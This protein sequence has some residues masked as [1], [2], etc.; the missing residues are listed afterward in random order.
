MTNS[1]ISKFIIDDIPVRL[2]ERIYPSGF[3]PLKKYIGIFIPSVRSLEI[4]EILT[5]NS[6]IQTKNIIRTTSNGEWKY[7]MIY[8]AITDHDASK[9]LK[10]KEVLSLPLQ[11]E[12]ADTEDDLSDLISDNLL[13]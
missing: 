10:I 11:I 1:T 8:Y 7:T 2:R 9:L 6:F 4:Y 3:Y 12:T 13:T 5:S